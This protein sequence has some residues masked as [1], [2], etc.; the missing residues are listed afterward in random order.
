[1]GNGRALLRTDFGDI[2]V[3]WR[4]ARQLAVEWA[5]EGINVNA[6]APSLTL[7]ER[8]TPHWNQRSPE[9]QAARSRG[10]TDR[11]RF[12]IAQRSLAPRSK[13]AGRTATPPETS[14]CPD[15]ASRNACASSSEKKGCPSARDQTKDRTSWGTS[16]TP[17][18]RQIKP[19]D[20]S[21]DRLLNRIRSQP[22][23]PSIRVSGSELKTTPS[24]GSRS[25][26]ARNRSRLARAFSSA[27]LR[28]ASDSRAS[29][30]AA[31][32]ASYSARAFCIS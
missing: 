30:P 29:P 13:P 5:K 19:S 18:L 32:T 31:P 17:S 10:R 6:I 2:G 7:T 9:A 11:R 15:S 3:S 16:E 20:S 1:M 27:M 8:I 14:P 12:F 23:L 21:R 25:Q 24:E 26:M 4:L 28:I 22:L